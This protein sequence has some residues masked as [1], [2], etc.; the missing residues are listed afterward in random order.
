MTG[1]SMT[2]FKKVEYNDGMDHY[3][4]TPG[5]IYDKLQEKGSDAVIGVPTNQPLTNAVIS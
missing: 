1:S 2:F 5:Q 3:R 4:L